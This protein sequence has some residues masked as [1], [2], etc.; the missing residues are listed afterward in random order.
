M[1]LQEGI[2]LDRIRVRINVQGIA[3]GVGAEF[4]ARALDYYLN[5]KDQI[6]V[7]VSR[8]D[9]Y[10]VAVNDTGSGDWDFTVGVIDPLPS[11]LVK[12]ADMIGKLR[13]LPEKV[14]W[15]INMDN[16]GVNRRELRRFLGFMPDFSQ[17]AVPRELI[18]RA[19]YNC[20]ELEE[21]CPLKGIEKLAEEI[22][23]RT[24]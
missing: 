8:P 14:F 13:E 3:D 7:F 9:K 16:E 21:L 23:K 15:I 5:R 17:E 12:G 4:T 20:V 22:R 19:E 24:S 1:R 10:E 6:R 11:S 18:T 2:F